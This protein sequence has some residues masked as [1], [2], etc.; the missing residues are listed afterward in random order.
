VTHPYLAEEPPVAFAHRGAHG[1]ETD[2]GENSFEAFERAVELGYRYLETDVHRTADG[3]VVALH[4]DT[5]DRTTDGEGA[6]SQR[7][8]GEIQRLTVSGGGRVPRLEELLEAFPDVRLNLDCKDPDTVP[9][10]VPLLQEGDVLERVCVGSFHH[11]TVTTLRDELGEDLCTAATSREVRL[12]VAASAVPRTSRRALTFAI[13]AD[14][15]QV[16]VR[17]GRT[18]IVTDRFV[19]TCHDAGLPVHVW[20]I[21]DRD[22]MHELLDL[23][24]DGLMTDRPITLRDVLAQRGDRPTGRGESD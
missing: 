10:L 22:E 3:V 2:L 23:G 17:D 19:E 14:C 13:N 16:P 1:D 6:V 20:T 18:R 7:A 11:G 5:L 15:V 8:W 12:L 4:D 24:V 21:D 9:F